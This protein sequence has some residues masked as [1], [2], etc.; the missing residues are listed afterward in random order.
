MV[1]KR[2]NKLNSEQ[3]Y[4]ISQLPDILGGGQKSNLPITETYY[5]DLCSRFLTKEQNA[6]VENMGLSAPKDVCDTGSEF[7]N[8]WYENERALRFALAIVRAGRLKKEV[9]NI[10]VSI[11]Q[12]IMQAARTAVGMEDPLKAEEFLYNYRM[13]Y[14]N[15]IQPLDYFGVDNVFAY[16]V[17]LMLLIRIKQFDKERGEASYHKIYDT[18]LRGD[19]K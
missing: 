16:G 15:S 13:G 14:L 18:I 17:R 9:P 1:G 8:K 5:R 4:L 10:P 2:L 3:I 7:L 11:T 19:A 6:I 12:D